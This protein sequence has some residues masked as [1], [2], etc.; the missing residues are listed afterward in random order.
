MTEAAKLV[1]IEDAVALIRTETGIPITKSRIHKDS[2]KG[3]TP[4]PTAVFGRRY[5]WQP[6]AMVAYARTLIKPQAVA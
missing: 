1:G 4:K 5:L 6:D 2:A 3:I